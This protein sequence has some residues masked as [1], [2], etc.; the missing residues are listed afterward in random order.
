MLGDLRVTLNGEPVAEP[1]VVTVR[2]RNT[3]KAAIRA[4][5]FDPGGDGIRLQFSPD[6]VS[7]GLAGGSVGLAESTALL[8]NLASHRVTIKPGLLNPGEYLDIQLFVDGPSQGETILLSARFVE[9][10]RPPRRTLPTSGPGQFIVFG[11]GGLGAVVGVLIGRAA[12]TLAASV[13]P[14][15]LVLIASILAVVAAVQY[16]GRR[17]R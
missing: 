1:R 4:D 13:L 11:F 2:V 10:S 9:Q 17:H 7:V 12:P 14:V 8:V 5:D 15:F 6:V 3:G 16:S